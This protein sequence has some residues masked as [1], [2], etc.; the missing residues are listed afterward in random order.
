M[1]C[2][3]YY[4]ENRKNHKYCINVFINFV[5]LTFQIYEY[6]RIYILKER[7]KYKNAQCSFSHGLILQ[8]VKVTLQSL[9]SCLFGFSTITKQYKRGG[10]IV[11]KQNFDLHCTSMSTNKAIP[12]KFWSPAHWKRKYIDISLAH[13]NQVMVMNWQNL[14]WRIK[15]QLWYKSA[16]VNVNM[17][18]PHRIL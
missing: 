16:S 18:G 1:L 2:L 4:Q 10:N 13:V 7:N 17:S 14:L 12:W 3:L 8:H 5:L 6:S 15:V 9:V 11:C